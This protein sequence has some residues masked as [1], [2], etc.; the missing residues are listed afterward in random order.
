MNQ[1]HP[2]VGD[3]NVLNNLWLLLFLGR[4]VLT[5]TVESKLILY[6][7]ALAGIYLLYNYLLFYKFNFKA[8]GL[9]D[10]DLG[11]IILEF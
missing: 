7:L 2:T 4:L 11:E 1:G 3:A 10:V 8:S 5:E 6:W 9:G